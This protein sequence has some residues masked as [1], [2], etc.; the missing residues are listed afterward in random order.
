MF[1]FNSL[2]YLIWEMRHAWLNSIVLSVSPPSAFWG[3]SHFFLN[4][5]PSSQLRAPSGRCTAVLPGRASGGPAQM[6]GP[7]QPQKKLD[8]DSVPSP[9]SALLSVS[10]WRTHSSFTVLRSSSSP[11][12]FTLSSIVEHNTRDPRGWG[13]LPCGCSGWE[14]RHGIPEVSMRGQPVWAC[15]VSCNLGRIPWCLFSCNQQYLS[16]FND[17]FVVRIYSI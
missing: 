4:F 9:V 14:A 7:P 12:A 1:A 11:S 3:C 17:S 16:I 6:A 2:P 5:L 15:V 8:P 10:S 13:S